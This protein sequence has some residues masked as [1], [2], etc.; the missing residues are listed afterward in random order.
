MSSS[1]TSQGPEISVVVAS[2]SGEAALARCLGSLTGQVGKAEVIAPTTTPAES[3]A[4][5]KARFPEVRFLAAPPDASVFRLRTLGVAQ[6][7]GRVVVLTEDHCTASPQWLESLAA[8]SRAGHPIVGGQVENGLDRR[9][10]DWALFF[11]EYVAFMPS[12]PEGTAN[13]VSGINVAYHRDVL[14][15]CLDAWSEAFHENEVHD[16]LAAAG[17]GLYRAQRAVVASHLAMSL[18]EAMRHLFGG[19]RHYGGYRKSR[20][21]P[22]DRVLLVLASPAIPAVLFWRIVRNVATRRPSRLA[23]MA[24][25]LPY[26]ACLLG[27]WSVGEALGY[28]APLP[29]PRLAEQPS[30]AS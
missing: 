23:T 8:A 26:I 1:E 13:V 25:G 22:A 9:I 15:G 19:A 11:C 14:L 27:A 4:R 2:F 24:L 16:A 28:L 3:I 12:Q 10:Y 5:L 20:T 18:L 6:A 21:D 7:R 17:I 29:R 30:G